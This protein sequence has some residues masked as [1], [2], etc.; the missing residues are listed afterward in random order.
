MKRLVLLGGGH[1]QISVLASL[2]ERPM[3]GCEVRLVTPYRRQIYSGMLPG[4]I[5]GHYPMD[6]CAIALD[7]LAA[8][9]GV[10]Q[11]AVSAAM[12]EHRRFRSDPRK[13]TR[14]SVAKSTEP[15]NTSLVA[16]VTASLSRLR[17]RFSFFSH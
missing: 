10:F 16:S 13:M 14:V 3:S 5:A 6:A 9:A 15:E 4:W 2:A 12:K 7:T 1:A 11:L 17:S 8:R